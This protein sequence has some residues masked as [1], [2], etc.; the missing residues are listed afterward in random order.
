M[1]GRTAVKKLTARS[2]AF[3]MAMFM[4]LTCILVMPG[5]STAYAAAMENLRI[6]SFTL[7]SDGYLTQ[8][9]WSWTS[10]GGY[11]SAP[12]KLA[13]QETEFTSDQLTDYG[14]Y[15]RSHRYSS[16]AS[17]ST[18]SGCGFAGWITESAFTRSSGGSRKDTVSGNGIKLDP[19]KKYYLYVWTLYGSVYPDIYV[20]SVDMTTGI[21]KDA[22]GNTLGTGQTGVNKW[23][24]AP[25]ITGWTYGDAAN[26][27]VYKSR[28]GTATVTYYMKD[29]TSADKKVETPVKAG[30]YTA[31]FEVAETDDYN[32]LSKSVDFT[33]EKKTVQLVWS[34]TTLKY[35]GSEQ[36]PDAKVD[37]SSLVG[38]DV[39]GVIITG[40]AVDV[41]TY[42]ATATA[43]DNKNYQLPANNTA[44]FT[45]QDDGPVTFMNDGYPYGKAMGSSTITLV[46]DT[47]GSP[48]SYQWQ[49][50]D[51][52]RGT[53][54]DIDGATEKTYTFTP[55]HGRWYRCVVD[56]IVSRPVKAVKPGS[57]SVLWTKP[58]SSWY[59]SNGT[60]AYMVDSDYR[61]DV[62]G[63]YSKNGKDYMMGTSYSRYWRAY[64]NSDAE[65]SA[66]NATSASLDAF[67]VAFDPTD[68]YNMIFDI[69]MASGQRAFAISSDTMIGNSST[70]GNYS[71][72]AAL[73]ASVQNGVVQQVSLV[74]AATAAQIVDDNPSF[75][76]KPATPAD[77]FW[78]GYYNSRKTYAYNTS[79]EPTIKKY[80]DIGGT[81][82]ATLVEGVDSGITMSWT[83]L[84][85]G[86]HV[87]FN[88]GVGRVID[89]GVVS[90]QV[91][92]TAENIW[93]LGEDIEY[94]V[95][96]DGVT[97]D[98]TSNMDG[99]IPLA[100]TDEN[101]KSYDFIGKNIT[102]AK[103][104]SEDTPAV[105]DIA[106]RPDT[107]AAP[108]ELNDKTG[109]TPADVEQIQ[110][111]GSLD[112][113]EI[114]DVTSTS[115]K[116]N[117]VD[118]QQY[119]Y[120][121]DGRNWTTLTN[122]N[123]AGNYVISG[124]TEGQ[125]V[126]IRTRITAKSTKPASLWS[127][128]K[129]VKTASKIGVTTEGWEGV[130]DGQQHSA[131]VIP[132]A[133]VS[134]AV[135]LY[136]ASSDEA[137]SSEM[138]V[139]KNA[140]EHTVYYLVYADGYAPS[141]G[142]E[143]VKIDKK[144]IRAEK[145]L[146]EDD[147]TI[148]G[149]EFSGLLDG[150]ELVY[151]DDYIVVFWGTTPGIERVVSTYRFALGDTA[152]TANYTL[153]TKSLDMVHIHNW[154]YELKEG[155]NDRIIAYCS[156]TE[157]PVHCAYQGRDEAASC[158]VSAESREYDGTVYADAAVKNWI[159]EKTG[160]EAVLSY[161]GTGDTVYPASNIAPTNAG[162]YKAVVNMAGVEAFAE[163]EIQKL[164][165]TVELNMSDY[166]YGDDIDVPVVS[167]AQ[168][169]PEIEYYYTT[170]NQNTDGTLWENSTSAEPGTYYMYA[171]VNATDNYNEY[172][173][174]PVAFSVSAR[175]TSSEISAADVVKTYDGNA[176]GITLTGDIPENAVVTYGTSEDACDET[177]SPKYSQA[178]DEPYTVYY[179]VAARGYNTV[180]G[181]A[182]I[183][184]NKRAL[185]I[186]GIKAES[187]AY[188]GGDAAVLDYSDVIYDG[189]VSGEKLE[190]TATGTFEDANA[191]TDKT[192]SI[193]DVTVTGK[194]VSNYVIADGDIQSTAKADITKAGTTL[195]V[196][197]VAAKTYGGAPFALTVKCSRTDKQTF[198]SS[199]TKVVKVDS[200]G[201]VTIVGAGTATVTVSV[202]G[203]TNYKEATAK[204]AIT[205][206][207]KAIRVT[208]NDASKYEGKADPKFS[209]TAAGLVGKDKLTGIIIKRTAGEKSGTYTI[210]VSQKAGSNPNYKITFAI[211][212]LVIKKAPWVE[213]SGSQLYRMNLPFFVMKG[214]GI[215]GKVKQ[216]WQKVAGA[217]GYDVYWSY[218]NGKNNYNKLASAGKA[219]TY[220]DKNLNNKREYKYFTVAYK[221]VGGKK[222]YIGRTNVIHVSMPNAT[223]T[224]AV[225][226]TVN[227]KSVVLTKGKT[228]KIT[229]KQKLENAKKKPLN[230]LIS[231]EKYRT[232]NAKVVTISRT[233]VITAKA[234]G[235]C[236]VYVMADNGVN[237]TIKVT[238]K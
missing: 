113:I 177:E 144:V 229:Y 222:V 73:M 234:K 103:K 69:D 52:K 152:N 228:F 65:P 57:D 155:R 142:T 146:V 108:S 32:G 128:P 14:S 164:D 183:T 201:K 139:F 77:Y 71:D 185:A 123:I 28:Y 85:S 167:G 72:G 170:E 83:N 99:K 172:V 206:N 192:V 4:T 176:Y 6:S 125:A 231:T 75:V 16:W 24:T 106:A 1:R 226:V 133:G 189:I 115:I 9:G 39:C 171:K 238:V 3:L 36:I 93:D 17:A 236:T 179:K 29:G 12:C 173:T 47:L 149:I 225:S 53:F 121:V 166:T 34:N 91:D 41:G 223:C 58:Y 138:P 211:G 118:G 132:A 10:S 33:I 147:Y 43:L 205:V 54:E 237:A 50:S 178:S 122:T 102:I 182:T 98:I 97:Y 191:G 64:G 202:A 158:T 161:E 235:T 210:K 162:T 22:S 217:T 116:I 13:I 112:G 101:G 110:N 78:I 48:S 233:G 45:I 187:K 100:G 216:S 111:T 5:G 230:H 67:R 27:P 46:A 55:V 199:N 59:I 95:T 109:L 160:V 174:E 194:T 35:T 80:A 168:E 156:E 140:G 19:G 40:A 197:R 42:T 38:S 76:L 92:Y 60:M 203:N 31:V 51:S 86:G 188:D 66:G 90:G 21:V 81:K 7:S 175:S 130:Y 68:P 232:S 135:V 169:N 107:P 213:P 215:S 88:F 63:H 62:V 137:Y 114:V 221:K 148:Q 180:T 94:Q 151:D 218:C 153:E 154:T 120:S 20:G 26:Q 70:S 186:S 134:G 117:P 18:P 190:I 208:A 204:A 209:Y 200:T 11:A 220:T 89:I 15:A 56:G 157:F 37:S 30:D 227:K 126:Q 141:Y 104:D 214:K 207:R 49:S 127:E 143:T 184:I 61:F 131:S 82:V 74:G 23:I 195:T 150:D 136:S 163:F 119:Q 96:A 84:P 2:V 124:I 145:V 129:T 219:L 224:N 181:H 105:M 44:T 193:T 159:T 165:Q 79:T 198:T 212:R 25:S 196:A 87:Y 8:V